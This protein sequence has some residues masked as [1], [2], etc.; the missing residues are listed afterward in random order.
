LKQ[1]NNNFH[2][3]LQSIVGDKTMAF[4]LM[5]KEMYTGMSDLQPASP[6]IDRGIALQKVQLFSSIPEFDSSSS[7][8]CC[9]L[10]RFAQSSV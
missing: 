1:L 6:T 4:L 8:W 9:N 2:S 10:C 5:D 7:R 3:K